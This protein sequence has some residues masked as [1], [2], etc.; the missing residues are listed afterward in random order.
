MPEIVRS[1][2]GPPFQ[3][4]E[5]AAFSE[6]MGFKHRLITPE[7]LR[8]NGMVERFM[9]NL[10][11]VIR[12]ASV[13]KLNWKT[14]LSEFLRNYRAT[15]HTTTNESLSLL[16]F[17]NS[18]T[19]RLPQYKNCF[20]HDDIDSRA[21]I[22]DEKKRLKNKNYIDQII[23]TKQH[24]FKI[25]DFVLVKQTQ[26]NKAMSAFKPT[27]YRIK[28]IKGNMIVANSTEDGSSMERNCSFF[29]KW[30]EMVPNKKKEERNDKPIKNL[31]NIHVRNIILVPNKT[32]ELIKFTQGFDKF[33]TMWN[34]IKEKN[35]IKESS[36]ICAS[37][38]DEIVEHTCELVSWK[39]SDSEDS[40]STT[41]SR[42][43]RPERL[44]EQEEFNIN[45]KPLDSADISTQVNK[46][47]TTATVRV[48][49]ETIGR[50]V[51]LENLE[52]NSQCPLE[53]V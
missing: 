14:R 45:E 11:K 41:T 2:N 22:S 16:F 4:K 44:K 35:G 25:G 10:G 21:R 32:S 42:M 8:A 18:K 24:C 37:I 39:D 13:D 29:L 26:R 3:S 38:V 9:K 31:R 5:F 34:K 49:D 43:I 40:L 52:T 15:P 12:T 19:T 53:R 7:W 30:E 51:S 46:L 17:R 33:V 1:D 47:V 50:I 27:P 23:R 6:F 28:E 48:L 20:K 36:S